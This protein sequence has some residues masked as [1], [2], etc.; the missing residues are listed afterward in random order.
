MLEL[1]GLSFSYG[2]ARFRLSDVSLSLRPGELLGVLGPNG[3]GKSTL[4]RLVMRLLTPER[5]NLFLGGR[6]VATFNSDDYAKLVAYVPQ[7]TRAAFAFT[8]TETVLMGRSPHL[9]V[10]GFE[11]ESDHA[12]ARDAL[13][14]VDAA[15]FADVMLDELSGGERQRVI[16]ARA[17]AQEADLL[18]LDEPGSSL[19]IRHQYALYRLLR[20]LTTGK[21]RACLVTSHDVNVAAA[22]CDRLL[23]MRGG[24]V[25]ATGR[26][27]EVLTARRIAE[28]YGIEAE[29][30]TR[31]DG[32]IVVLPRAD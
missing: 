11:S 23:L 25:V 15:Q 7:E 24:G 5:G 14:Q 32:R 1:A 31:P 13:E 6:P 12:A 16:L 9:G 19:D 17:L 26:P 22:F 30:L 2:D 3:C 21:G 8:A 18:V 28:V 10:L 27:A 29:V 4:A 20:E